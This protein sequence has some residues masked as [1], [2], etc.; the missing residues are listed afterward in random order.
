MDVK[1]SAVLILSSD[2]MTAALVGAAMEA[3]GAGAVFARHDESPR[4]ALLRTRPAVVAIDCEHDEACSEAFLGPVV[5]TGAAVAVFGPPRLSRDLLG[6]SR[7][8][9]IAAFCLPDDQEQLL[10]LVR[11]AVHGGPEA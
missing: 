3:T 6:A 8:F 10:E 5:M 4:E 2:P 11:R 1:R 7:R 9:S